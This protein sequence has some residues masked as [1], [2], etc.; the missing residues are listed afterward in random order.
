ME[1]SKVF[2]PMK[3][4]EKKSSS[5]PCYNPL[6][7]AHHRFLIATA[8]AVVAFFAAGHAILSMRLL[9]GWSAFA[10]AATILAWIVLSTGD[11]Y[12]ARRT[13]RIQDSS[14][15]LLFGLVVTAA[16]V[17]LFT[18]G[19]LLA[20]AKSLPPLQLAE[21]VTVSVISIVFS[22]GLVHTM[23]ALRYAHHYFFN[24]REEE[25]HL[26][27]GGLIFPGKGSPNYMDFAYFSFVIGMTCQVSDVQV[28]ATHMRALALLHGIISF[29]FNTA[30]LAM[31]VNIVASLL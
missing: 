10:L 1:S 18:V 3:R 15:T 31:F 20:S 27:S 16:T 19:L 2:T 26:A 23:F 11:P 13:A 25:R 17:S 7:D 8:I 29:C 22:W 5:G 28:S 30:I 14:A 24:A 9:M 6:L 21:H 12:E 4:V